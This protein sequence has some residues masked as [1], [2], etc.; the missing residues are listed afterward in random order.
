MRGLLG[1]GLTGNRIEEKHRHH[2]GGDVS[3]QPTTSSSALSGPSVVQRL[4]PLIE[5]L[6]SGS[7]VIV[8]AMSRGRLPRSSV[9]H[10]AAIVSSGRL[11][12]SAR[13]AAW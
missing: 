7:V 5:T 9:T 11:G 4:A 8:V 12:T 2:R 6:P 1:P 10:K 3:E 13:S